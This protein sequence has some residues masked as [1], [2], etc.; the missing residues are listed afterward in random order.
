MNFR[1]RDP[2]YPFKPLLLAALGGVL[3]AGCA[4]GSRTSLHPPGEVPYPPKG[5]VKAEEIFHLPTGIR[6]PFDGMM[7][8][9]SG[10]RLVCIG[11]THDNIHAHR[12]EL[13]VIRELAR[14]FP[15]KIAIG[16]EMFR[17]PQQEALDRWTRGELSELEFLKA[18]KWHENW[19]SDFRY[20]R[21]ILDFARENRIDVIALN[22]PRD[23]E[24]EVSRTGLDNV[25]A[26]LAA[27]LPVTAPPDPYQRAMMKAV[28]GAHLPSEGMFDSFFRVQMLWEESMASRIVDYLRSPRGEGKR[29]V[30]VTGGWH[31]RYG[32]GVPK[33]A[34]RRMPMP[35]VIVLPEEIE[36][37]EEKADQQMEVDLPE[38][39]LLRGDFAWMVPYEDLEKDKVRMGVRIAED[40]GKVVVE[41]VEDGSPAAK[42]GIL[43]KSVIV[44]IDGSPVADLTDVFYL[45]GAKREG[46]K[47]V[48]VVRRDG[49]EQA[50]ELTFFKMPK[51]KAH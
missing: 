12:V 16:M 11:E 28:Y 7:D 47:A 4:A 17:E 1:G 30:T 19:G 43:A 14:R 46:D 41:G 5:E 27:K 32:F 13:L 50:L 10:A 23:L 6:M 9:V 34:I 25:P 37:P 45:V 48:V 24:R 44:S 3:L 15:G 2:M 42:A 36:I 33:K 18:S 38:I 51:T 26:D 39:P 40:D 8:M 22:P 20:Y 31:V 49:A 29:M 21:D 35:Y